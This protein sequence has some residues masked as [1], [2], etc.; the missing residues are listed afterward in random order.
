MYA[1]FWLENMR[2]RDHLEDLDIDE[3]IILKWFLRKQGWRAW[4][5]LI[6][7]VIVTSSRLL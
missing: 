3:R 6:W 2:G 1:E 4:I 5:G 7:L